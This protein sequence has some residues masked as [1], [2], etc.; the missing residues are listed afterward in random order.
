MS[1]GS[2]SIRRAKAYA[3][4]NLTG[5]RSM[6]RVSPASSTNIF[7]ISIADGKMRFMI[8]EVQMST[9]GHVQLRTMAERMCTQP[10]S[11]GCAF[12]KAIGRKF[13]P[14]IRICLC[15]LDEEVHYRFLL[16][17]ESTMIRPKSLHDVESIEG[18]VSLSSL[19]R[20]GGHAL[21]HFGWET[22]IRPG[23]LVWY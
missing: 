13:C 9:T 10:L 2:H 1:F 14:G 20:H 3:F 22:D 6:R 15:S 18:M 12:N 11:S 17:H 5:A 21:L 23:W 19:M 16:A 8:A 4:Y 7:F